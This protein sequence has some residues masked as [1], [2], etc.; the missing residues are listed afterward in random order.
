MILSCQL[1]WQLAA[2]FSCAV[3]EH[4]KRNILHYDT[5]GLT[6]LGFQ[7]RINLQKCRCLFK[8]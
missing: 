1:K 7:G 6:F 8:K 2:L 4:V 5:L 3:V